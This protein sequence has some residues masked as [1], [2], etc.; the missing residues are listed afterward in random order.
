MMKRR[1][2][3]KVLVSAIVC[4]MILFG[5]GGFLHKGAAAEED[6]TIE[7]Y[8]DRDVIALDQFVRLTVVV[9]GKGD[10]DVSVANNEGLNI[11]TRGRQK[12]VQ[13]IN[14]SIVSSLVYTYIVQATETGE[15]AIDV[16]A[17]T[18]DGSTKKAP[19]ITLQVTGAGQEAGKNDTNSQS[20]SGS[21]GERC[22][23]ITL[24]MGRLPGKTGS[25]SLKSC[26]RSNQPIRVKAY[27][28][29]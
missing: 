15:Y 24:R 28:F 14:T 13:I 6:F 8:L 3:K 27:L 20:S 19:T 17:T 10:I 2:S 25:I 29:P 12:R 7:A 16:L 22:Q 4:L 21:G 9:E 1:C 26:L 5:F 18:D 11:E 23:P